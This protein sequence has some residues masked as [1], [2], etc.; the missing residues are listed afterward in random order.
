MKKG[1]SNEKYV[2]R[3]SLKKVIR[4]YTYQWYIW[5]R[6]HFCDVCGKHFAEESDV[7]KHHARIHDEPGTMKKTVNNK[8]R[9]FICEVYGKPF[10]FKL[11]LNN[12]RVVHTGEKPYTYEV[13]GK[14]FELLLSINMQIDNDKLSKR[15][16]FRFHPKNKDGMKK[17]KSATYTEYKRHVC[18][19][20]GKVLTQYCNLKAHM[21]I[22]KGEKPFECEICNKKFTQKGHLTR[23]ISMVHM[24]E[25]KYP[26]DV[27]GKHFANMSCV[28]NHYAALHA[29]PG[30]ARKLMYTRPRRFSCEVC[31]KTFVSAFKLN[32]HSHIHTGE[33]PYTCE[34]CGK[35][36]AY[37]DSLSKH[38]LTHT[39]RKTSRKRPFICRICGAKYESR[40][41]L[42][43]HSVVHT[44]EKPYSCDL[45]GKTFGWKKSVRLHKLSSCI[46]KHVHIDNNEPSKRQVFGVHSKNKNDLENEKSA[47]YTESKHHVCRE[48]GKVLSSYSNLK[49]HTL[50]HKPKRQFKCKICNKKFTQKCHLTRHISTVHMGEKKYSCDVCGKHFS[51][52]SYVG[53][54]YVALHAEP[55]TIKMAIKKKPRPFSCEVCGK[56]F[57]SKQSVKNHSVMHTGEKPYNCDVCSKGFA[58]KSDVKRHMLIHTRQN[59]VKK[60]PFACEIC[61]AKYE[62]KRELRQ[63]SVVHTGA[64]PFSCDLCGK[65]FGWKKSV[66]LHKLSSCFAEQTHSALHS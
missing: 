18:Q 53:K 22:H 36:F 48:C 46:A 38:I 60:K 37:K 50:I 47:T 35:C 14:C 27:C 8:P 15:E 33:K 19:E 20:C 63:H 52:M 40:Y 4:P 54:H 57:L 26:C 41:K 45:C 23:H 6:K 65:T 12:H 24:G 10:M 28:R 17:G 13:C 44:G 39:G 66:R 61:G 43:Q 32:H 9:P 1:H 64:K 5:E 59:L 11:V 2:T 55:G 56:R 30:T 31:G 29:E 62:K 51:E 25:K 42:L 16:V 34:F 3:S 7:R 58:Y 49:R 21:L